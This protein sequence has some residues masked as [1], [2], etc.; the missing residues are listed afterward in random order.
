MRHDVRFGGVR[1][2]SLGIAMAAVGVGGIWYL[3]S[4][5]SNPRQ[6]PYIRASTSQGISDHEKP[7]RDEAPQEAIA[8]GSEVERRSTFPVST[9]EVTL[10]E[11]SGD[12]QDSELQSFLAQ[13][14]TRYL[15]SFMSESPDI[16]GWNGYLEMLA[17]GAE[18][19]PAS[20]HDGP[21][22]TQGSFVIPGTDVTIAFA[23]NDDGYKIESKG[24]VALG[25][26]GSVE[27]Q[28]S[29]AFESTTGDISVAHGVVQFFP[30]DD[31][32]FYENGP[33]GYIYQT[34]EEQMSLRPMRGE[35]RDDGQYWLIVPPTDAAEQVN[36]GG[37]GWAYSWLVRLRE[38]ERFRPL[39]NSEGSPR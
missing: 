25:G 31:Q 13:A 39:Q 37:L 24:D 29:A 6:A 17:A 19:D 28:T 9:Q 36:A 2:W 30:R 15:A 38:V 22:G 3:K 35:T 4:G 21:D 33:V 7:L 8:S 18:L 20:V 23:I 26:L 5:S 1:R 27:F 16:L 12:S 10:E 32:R 14:R 11:A 34:G